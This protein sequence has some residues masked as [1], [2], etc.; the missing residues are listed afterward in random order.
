ME[1]SFYLHFDG[2]QAATLSESRDNAAYVEVSAIQ[3][4]EQEGCGEDRFG[5]VTLPQLRGSAIMPEFG[6]EEEVKMD[7]T[8]VL[9]LFNRWMATPTA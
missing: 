1:E 5:E 8:I 6:K 7:P 9:N 3:G 2:E 4:Q